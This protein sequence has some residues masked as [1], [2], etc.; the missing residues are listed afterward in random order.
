LDSGAT[1]GA[2]VVL[3]ASLEVSDPAQLQPVVRMLTKTQNPLLLRLRPLLLARHL[4]VDSPDIRQ[5]MEQCEFGIDQ[6]T[7]IL[8]WTS[9]EVSFVYLQPSA[10]A[11]A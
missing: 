7:L 4:H 8:R 1:F 2:F 6:Q 9:R 10:A 5:A 3:A 11:D